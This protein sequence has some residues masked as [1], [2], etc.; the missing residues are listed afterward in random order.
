MVYPTRLL[1]CNE[2][3][4]QVIIHFLNEK[5]W[6]RIFNTNSELSQKST[7]KQTMLFKTTVNCL[8]N[9]IWCYLV[10]G[11]FDWKIGVFQ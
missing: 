8:F 5:T 7:E 4:Y 3:N 6:K 1:N 2:K 10:I 11:C 9:N